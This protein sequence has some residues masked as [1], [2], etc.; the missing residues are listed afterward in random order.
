MICDKGK[1]SESF[2]W[3][4]TEKELT[5]YNGHGLM[6]K[7]Q[8]GGVD[9]GMVMFNSPGFATCMSGDGGMGL[10]KGDLIVHTPELCKEG[11]RRNN[12]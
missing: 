11:I 5:E 8:G 12:R 2:Y 10:E 6:V 7:T 4:G 1:T 9:N 3:K